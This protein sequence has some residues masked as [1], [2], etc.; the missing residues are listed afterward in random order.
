MTT[1]LVEGW[2]AAIPFTLKADGAA[3]DLTSL[4]V[5]LELRGRDG[6]P[7]NTTSKVAVTSAAA[8]QVTFT[9][10]A[11]DLVASLSPY[12]ARFVVTDTN[13]KV[14]KVPNSQQPDLWKVGK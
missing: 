7:V 3:L 9:P 6:S 2:T 1:E 8:G 12:E 14:L 4:T 13:G 10:V 11:G 5:T